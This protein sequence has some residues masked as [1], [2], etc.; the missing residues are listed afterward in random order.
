MF[1]WLTAG[2]ACINTD[3]VK[4][5]ARPGLSG[6]VLLVLLVF[7]VPG[8]VVAGQSAP[9][10]TVPLYQVSGDGYATLAWEA[11]Q[12]E[13]S[14]LYK[15]TETFG[16]EVSIHYTESTRLRARRAAPGKYGFVLQHCVKA[17]ASTPDCGDASDP[18][19][20]VVNE[21][22][23]TALLD[24]LNVEKLPI[25]TDLNTSG[26][27][28]QM[29]PGHWYNPAKS[30]HGWSFYWSNRLALAQDD[31][32]FGN[33][34]DLVGIW[35]TFEAKYLGAAAGCSAC[36]PV[37]G[38][39]RPVA[40]K[41]R[42]VSTGLDSYGGS[43]FVSRDDGS[44]IWVGSADVI[45]GANNASATIN[46][47]ASFKKE[48][49]SGSDPLVL[50]LGSDP[51]KTNDIS[52]YSGLW[53]RNGDDRYLVVTNIGGIAEVE[54]L[55]FH[56]DAGDP[57]W[58][59]AV[60]GGSAVSNSTN[61][62]LAFLREGY[63]PQSGPPTGW[64][65]GWYMSGCDPA[66]AVDTSNR[67][68]RRYFSGL[69]HEY[70]WAD[71]TLPGTAYSSGSISIGS[72]AAPVQLE[73]T[74]NF[75]GVSYQYAGGSS[76]ELT[77]ASSRCDVLLTWYT[78][79]NYPDA[80]VYAHDVSNNTYNKVAT[81]TQAAMVDIPFGLSV[82]GV[83]EFELH[84]GDNPQTTLM[85]RSGAFT[86]TENVIGPQPE[87]PPEPASPPNMSASSSSSKVGA[88]AGSFR[89]VESGS[90]SYS[91]PILTAPASGGV[92]PQVSLNYNSQSGNG[93]VGVGWSIGGV[94]A[95]SLCPQT[96]EQDGISGSRGIK[97]DGTDRFCLD[98]QRLVV[99]PSSG[100]YGKNGT[101]YRTEID[102]FAR[103][104]S[105]GMAGNG[106][107]WFKVERKDGSVL[108][109][110]N[111]SDSRIEARGAAN[112]ASVSTWAQNRF[113][114][115]A[116]NYILYSYLEKRHGS[117]RLRITGN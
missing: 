107:A 1:Q 16:N 80:T 21:V 96:I 52:H 34:Y 65:Q 79:G 87:T 86:V 60:I 35:Y 103:I 99:D 29:Q 38:A 117:G 49:L 114:D 27:P 44:E 62:C 64:S 17:N 20:L 63:S 14:G 37:T 82:A 51:A 46:W 81:S 47:S 11:E 109:Y 57:T 42:A 71:F 26:G 92:A 91:V 77:G 97:L 28:G 116:G 113:E 19:T 33:N 40:L 73:K 55:V 74:A 101:R 3:R 75:H 100:E 36:P 13:N 94:S 45:F 31:P 112:P 2:D 76:C 12:R 83:Y 4:N 59:Q 105:Y 53:Q 89:V 24:E 98:G 93:E 61:F 7:Q 22:P 108:E 25:N 39:Y 54:T 85:A 48:S 56:D 23:P 67:N 18:L 102:S 90:A 6:W 72:S 68:G 30:G 106:P 15:I 78:D 84:M 110:G 115:R 41:L 70:Y 10:W 8:I 95:I 5:V 104:T 66:Q 69:E 43:L 111:S 32:L 88:T 50:L 58:V 9:G